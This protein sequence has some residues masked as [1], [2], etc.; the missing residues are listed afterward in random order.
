MVNIR[1]GCLHVVR[2]KSE[3]LIADTLFVHN[4]PFRYECELNLGELALYPDFTIINPITG[5]IAY[6]EHFGLMNVE[7]YAN[8][9]FSKLNIYAQYGV[10]PTINLIT[11]YETEEA[12][13]NSIPVENMIR[14]FWGEGLCEYQEI[15]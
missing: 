11:T 10:I 13:L 5:D 3:A 7:S 8:N 6:W 12:P 2:S 14:S 15:C 1:N 9:C 4:I